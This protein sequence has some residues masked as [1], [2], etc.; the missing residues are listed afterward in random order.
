MGPQFGG[1]LH[2]VKSFV[3][4]VAPPPPSAR[5]AAVRVRLPGGCSSAVGE[6]NQRRR[7]GV[8]AARAR[9]GA[10]GPG[11]RGVARRHAQG[12]APSA[13]GEPPARAGGRAAAIPG[14]R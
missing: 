3:V 12:G 2:R 13:H 4:A 14:R 10:H 9:P 5:G 11:R 7:E 1:P 6:E 8:G